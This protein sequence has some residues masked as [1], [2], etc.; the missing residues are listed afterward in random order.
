MANDNTG[1]VRIFEMVFWLALIMGA[2]LSCFWLVQTFTARSYEYGQ[3]ET[4]SSN[5]KF[6][7]QSPTFVMYPDLED[8]TR[9]YSNKEYSSVFQ[10]DKD[11]NA[12][13]KQY[14]LLL[15]GNYFP[16][17]EMYAGHVECD[18]NFTFLDTKG[19]D[20]INDTLYITIDFHAD[21]TNL[22]IETYGGQEAAGYWLTFFNSNGF[23]L[24][25]YENLK[26]GI[27]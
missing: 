1:K 14:D 16:N 13:T 26:G 27:T 25:I 2:I 3:I 6:V 5:L 18:L 10:I 7:L 24:R 11:F 8:T 4:V 17:V 21:T 19:Q 22:S 20:L 15:N 9:Y 23:D 12:D